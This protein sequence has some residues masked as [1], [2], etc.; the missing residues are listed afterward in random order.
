MALEGYKGAAEDAVEC[1]SAY[2]S[3]GDEDYNF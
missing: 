2:S 1:A 3:S